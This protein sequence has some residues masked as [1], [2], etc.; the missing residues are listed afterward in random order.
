MPLLHPSVP[1]SVPPG[2][3]DIVISGSEVKMGHMGDSVEV[4]PGRKSRTQEDCVC[5]PER[6]KVP[7]N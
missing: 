1:V 4:C 6:S 3:E 2:E 5:S 7:V